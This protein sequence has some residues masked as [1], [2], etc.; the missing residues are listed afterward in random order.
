MQPSF[1]FS[2]RENSPPRVH[3]PSISGGCSRVST[4]A[5]ERD[6]PTCRFA[7]DGVSVTR[8]SRPAGA[9]VICIQ[10]CAHTYTCER[11]YTKQRPTKEIIAKGTESYLAEI[12]CFQRSRVLRRRRQRGTFNICITA[13]H[14]VLQRRKCCEI[15]KVRPKWTVKLGGG[16][17]G[18]CVLP[19]A[20]L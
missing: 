16:W 17:Q 11:G 19:C 7:V 13:L 20:R 1:N 10:S 4:T 18:L 8:A 3:D 2:R 12:V 5:T 6:R 15:Q 9:L 14:H